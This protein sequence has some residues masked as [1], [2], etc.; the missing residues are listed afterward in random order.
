[1]I[2]V[3]EK[4]S[5]PPMN[6]SKYGY[7]IRPIKEGC[8]YTWLFLP[9][10]PGLGSEYLAD[11]CNKLQVPGSVLLLDFPQDGINTQG[12]LDMKCWQVGLI[13]LLQSIPHPVL[14]THSFSGMFALNLPELNE[15]LAGLVL[16]NTTTENSFFPHV[17]AMQER[18]HL[19]DLI[20]P[21]SQ[22]HLAPSNETYKEFWNTYKHYCFTAE[23][24]NEGEKIIPLF[25]FNN[26]AYHYAIEHFYPDYSCKWFPQ[27]IPVMT[28]ASENDFICPP[29]IFVENNKFQGKNSIHQIIE[30]AGHC[31]WLIYFNDVQCCF[32]DFIVKLNSVSMTK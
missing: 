14:V 1:M 17:S 21:A 29:R 6:Y 16:M 19:P 30:N 31:P 27:A 15:Y 11:L 3:F 12:K 28:I 13:D 5:K 7:K 4:D 9:G 25:A 2:T 32:N 23:E 18:H 22:Y 10:G 26:A 24:L 20:P 8:G